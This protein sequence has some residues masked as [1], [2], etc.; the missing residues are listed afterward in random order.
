MLGA[1]GITGFAYHSGVLAAIERLTGWDPRT[2]EVIVG[3]SAGSGFGAILRGGVPVGEVLAHLLSAPAD[4]ETMAR[5]RVISGQETGPLSWLWFGPGSPRLLARELLRT[6]R[7]RPSR[8]ATSVLPNGRI[9]TDFLGDRIR[10]LHGLD[11]PAEA[12]WACALRLADGERVVFGLDRPVPTDVGTAVEASSAIPGFF[13]PVRIDGERYV[14]GAIHS[15][16][17]ADLLVGLDLDLVV[18]VSPMSGECR[19]TVRRLDAVSRVAS[20]RSLRE[21]LSSLR[22]DGL[23]VLVVEPDREEIRTMGAINMDPTRLV[24][25]LFQSSAATYRRLAQRDAVAR[26]LGILADA[27][28]EHARRPSVPY[29]LESEPRP[30]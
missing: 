18:I 19:Y 22:N 16:T 23:D 13:R 2:A 1:G 12:Y 28:Q 21:E 25:T 20:A 8:V 24:P 11:W 4:P 15:P 7:A 14:D 6:W 27:A 9:P 5:L 30:S 29:P 17:N 26:Q 3:T 10:A